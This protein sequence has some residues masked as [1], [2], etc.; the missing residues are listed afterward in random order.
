[1][2][3]VSVAVYTVKFL[4]VC[5][6]P[7]TFIQVLKTAPDSVVK[8]ISN[9]AL[10]AIS[11]DVGLSEDTKEYLHKYRNSIIILTSKAVSLARKRNLLKSKSKVIGGFYFVP[12]LLTATLNSLGDRLFED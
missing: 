1:M 12:T 6:D 9:A 7:V 11:G 4:S 5:Q 10:N 3:P 8:I 2:D